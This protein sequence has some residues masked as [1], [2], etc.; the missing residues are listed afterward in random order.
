MKTIFRA[1]QKRQTRAPLWYAAWGG[2]LRYYA[3]IGEPKHEAKALR[4][5]VKLVKLPPREQRRVQQRKIR[6]Q[7]ERKDQRDQP[8]NDAA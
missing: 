7:Q 1:I 3:Y 6:A 4:K 2:E 5:L 8:P